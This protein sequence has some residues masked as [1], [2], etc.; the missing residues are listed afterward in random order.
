MLTYTSFKRAGKQNYIYELR[1]DER[2]LSSL[3]K[4]VCL[5][6][7]RESNEQNIDQSLSTLSE[8]NLVNCYYVATK[9]FMT[10]TIMLYQRVL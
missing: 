10:K 9:M 4:K 2:F 8:M 7:Y 5:N 6:H 3:I 1:T